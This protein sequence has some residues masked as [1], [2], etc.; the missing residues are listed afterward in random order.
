VSPEGYGVLLRLHYRDSLVLGSYPVV[1][2]GDSTTVGAVVVVRYLMREAARSFFFDSGAVRLRR[3]RDRIS[4]TANGS[5]SES[6]MRTPTQIQY[7][8]IALP[9]RTDTVTCSFAW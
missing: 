9:A 1:T 6:G 8:D 5:G 4:G 3:D 7:H 2:P